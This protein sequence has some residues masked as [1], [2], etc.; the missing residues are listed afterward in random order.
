[1]HSLVSLGFFLQK[2]KSD[3]LQTFSNFKTQVELQF[4]YKIKIIQ[5]EWGGEYRAF[6]DLLMSNDIIHKILALILMNKMRLR[7]ENIVI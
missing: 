7:R 3:V 2:H 4:G 6:T 5:I 1:M